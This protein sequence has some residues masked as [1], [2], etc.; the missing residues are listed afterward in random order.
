MK[1]R[2]KK[3]NAQKIKYFILFSDLLICASKEVNA[4]NKDKPTLVF[5]WKADLCNSDI[6]FLLSGLF[7]LNYN[8]YYYYYYLF[9]YFIISLL[10]FIYYY[11][12]YFN[13][14]Y[15]LLLLLLLLRLFIKLD[16]F[17]NKY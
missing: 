11:Y 10:L 16:L 6:D 17:I 9:Y 7:I 8:Y 13:I 1:V 3:N 12:Y 4:K 15:Y 5:S 2:N 14:Y